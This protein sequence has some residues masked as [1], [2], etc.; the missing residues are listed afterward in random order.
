MGNIKK[1]KLF[2][3][4][5]T[6]PLA[7]YFHEYPM[8]AFDDDALQ[9][10]VSPIDLSDAIKPESF[11]DLLSAS[12]YENT[13][14][15][16][17]MFP[18]GSGYVAVNRVTPADITGR[19]IGWYMNWMNHYS[20][21]MVPGHGNLRFKIWNPASHYDHFNV[22][23]NDGKD[24]VLSVECPDLGE[25]DRM[26]IT[27]RHPCD[28]FEYGLTQER[29][30]ALSAAGCKVNRYSAWES[31][32]FPGAHMTLGIT[33]PLP[34]G[35]T[36]SVTRE[37][38]GWRPCCGKLVREARTPCDEAYLKKTVTHALT[39]WNHLYSIL[40]SLYAEYHGQ[41]MDAD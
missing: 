16:Y 20:K 4:E 31:F 19:M 8:Q 15:G 24:G 21:S 37:W 39:E 38:I 17:C 2:A 33:R 41:P 40:P 7:K 23:W 36:E 18:D 11:L 14:T 10:L 35:L 27:I 25:G 6:M 12:G 34:N 29:L 1:Q 28:L 9:L 22:N 13:K 3:E 32:D 26:H 5:E 30:D